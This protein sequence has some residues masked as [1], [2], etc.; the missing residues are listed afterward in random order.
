MGSSIADFRNYLTFCISCCEFICLS[1]ITN[2]NSMITYHPTTHRKRQ[3]LPQADNQQGSI[4][5][6][7]SQIPSFSPDLKIIWKQ[8]KYI[9]TTNIKNYHSMLWQCQTLPAAQRYIILVMYFSMFK[10]STVTSFLKAGWWDDVNSA[11]ES[12]EYVSLANQ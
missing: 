2:F 1:D 9:I 12:S 10:I 7:S 8:Y 3:T 4:I 11:V 5:Y 6:Q